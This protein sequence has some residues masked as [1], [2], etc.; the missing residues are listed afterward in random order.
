[1]TL[2]SRSQRVRPMSF[3]S[4]RVGRRLSSE[5]LE[6]VAGG[7]EEGYD[8]GAGETFTPTYDGSDGQTYEQDV[9]DYDVSGANEAAQQ[10]QVA[11]YEQGSQPQGAEY[12]SDVV[13]Y[14]RSGAQ[15]AAAEYGASQQGNDQQQ[16]VDAYEYGSQPQQTDQSYGYG[17]NGYYQ[18]DDG[19][20]FQSFPDGSTLAQDTEGNYTTTP[21]PDAF[22]QQ[23]DYQQPEYIAGGTMD[24]FMPPQ[25]SGVENTVS[26]GQTP[27]WLGT[28]SDLWQGALYG[29]FNEGSANVA[30]VTG[31]LGP[32]FVPVVGAVAGA[33]DMVADVRDIWNGKPG[34]WLNLGV[35]ALATGA[36]L[37][38]AGGYVKGLALG[39][40]A[41]ANASRAAEASVLL[42][43]TGEV[44]PTF[45]RI[46]S[47]PY[48]NPFG[49]RA[50]ATGVGPDFL[51]S[52]GGTALPLSRAQLES[53]LDTAIANHVPGFSSLGTSRAGG[54]IYELPKPAGAGGTGPSYVLRVEPGEGL[55]PSRL[56]TTEGLESR[57]YLTPF[58]NQF[59]N[60]LPRADRRDL[61]HVRLLP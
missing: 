33:R 38:G 59:P 36:G 7:D 35:D 40:G 22:S 44:A 23:S 28:P 13:D 26:P 25:M 42:R 12:Q 5:S 58:G 39:G 56:V 30:N 6:R 29:R 57:N 10:E 60:G 1:M 31:H 52:P 51:V 47:A 46:A 9:A 54:S 50:A 17:D 55:A 14:D 61:G 15:Q 19:S 43:G 27:S 45:E 2:A 41:A 32:Y 8:G 34:A 53:S 11:A 48:M 49:T 24:G 37:I 16:M 3:R 21:A 18:Y 4:R 20:A